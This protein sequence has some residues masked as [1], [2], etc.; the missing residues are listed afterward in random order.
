M[1]VNGSDCTEQFECP[2]TISSKNT[3]S[4]NNKVI[5]FRVTETIGYVAFNPRGLKKL[6]ISNVKV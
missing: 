6:G 3:I 1:Q 2:S 4:E 5:G